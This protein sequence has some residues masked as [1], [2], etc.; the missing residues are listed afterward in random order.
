MA[1]VSGPRASDQALGTASDRPGRLRWRLPWSLT[2]PVVL[3][4]LLRLPSLFEP[5]WYTD[6]AGYA[7]T[8]WLMMHGK[9][10]Y[11]SVWNNKPPSCSGSTSSP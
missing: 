5:H 9:V 1:S 10:L 3:L 2:V 6:E 8:A 7:N 4:L 11:L